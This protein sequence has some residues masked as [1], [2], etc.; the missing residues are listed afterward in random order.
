MATKHKLDLDNITLAADEVFGMEFDSG[1]K[2]YYIIGRNT[3]LMFREIVKMYNSYAG[4]KYTITAFR[5]LCK[6]HDMHGYLYKFNVNDIISFDD[7]CYSMGCRNG[8][9]IDRYI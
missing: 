2:R 9:T 8:L 4:T 6:E 3:K 5:K 7:D 1:Y